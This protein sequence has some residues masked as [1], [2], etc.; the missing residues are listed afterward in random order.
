MKK[1]VFLFLLCILICSC[2]NQD[3]YDNKIT[4]V[5]DVDY[6]LI[7]QMQIYNNSVINQTITRG[8]GRKGAI[9][10]ADIAGGVVSLK[11]GV[12][13]GKWIVSATGGSGTHLVALGVLGWTVFKSA[14]ASRMAYQL[15]N[16][17]ECSEESNLN[18]VKNNIANKFLFRRFNKENINRVAFVDNYF[19]VNND[20]IYNSIGS[21]HND[22]LS[23][24]WESSNDFPIDDGIELGLLSFKNGVFLQSIT[25]VIDDDDEV[26]PIE[27]EQ[28]QMNSYGIAA[29]SDDY[30]ELNFCEGLHGLEALCATDD[31]ESFLD[32]LQAANYMSQ[33]VK[34]VI[35]YLYEALMQSVS[36]E[37]DLN[38]R[39][40]TYKS[41][42]DNAVNLS[43]D[44]KQ[45]LYQ[46]L[47]I[48]RYSY[49]YWSSRGLL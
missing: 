9:L 7:H 40:A 34:Y 24:V 21:M 10:A 23:D 47:E 18:Y 26:E 3:E 27:E 28:F 37:Q 8:T 32:N 11:K 33:N 17:I 12:E 13:V 39:I 42:V 38:D 30:I 1:S 4:E 31:Y 5:S 19:I 44:D 35:K 41:F 49:K 25:P 2:S 14:C 43:N 22:L 45:I 46:S 29:I 16:E 36:T 6:Q 48:A 15:L 20:S